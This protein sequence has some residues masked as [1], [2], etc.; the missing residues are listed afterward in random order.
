MSS[1]HWRLHL[2]YAWFI[3]N[4][5][6][7][8]DNRVSSVRRYTNSYRFWL[9]MLCV[10]YARVRLAWTNFYVSVWSDCM[11]VT[12]ALLL[13]FYFYCRNECAHVQFAS[14]CFS[15]FYIHIYRFN[16]IK[17][18]YYYRFSRL[19]R[20]HFIRHT[21]AKETYTTWVF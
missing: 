9:W 12:K 18:G 10:L 19:H 15:F 8:R 3:R 20:A 2:N 13:W 21:N 6:S 5:C 17:S 16:L 7:T 1:L 4:V 14:N 11:C